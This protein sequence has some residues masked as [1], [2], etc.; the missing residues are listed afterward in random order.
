MLTVSADLLRAIQAHGE[1]AYPNEGAGLLIGQADE[2]DAVVLA[3]LPVDN[4]WAPAEQGR[5]YLISPQA[6]LQ[7]EAEA[8]RR[9]LDVVGAFH[10]HP[11]HPAVPSEWD[12]GW[13]WPNFVYVITS[14]V[15]GRAAESRAWRLQADRAAFSETPITA[16]QPEAGPAGPKE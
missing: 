6:M 9:G 3:L 4:A 16:S 7:A 2:A 12:R 10:S 13:A 14:V 11:D 8:A 1:A 5:R 15:G